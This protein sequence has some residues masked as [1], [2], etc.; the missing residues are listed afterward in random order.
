MKKIILSLIFIPVLSI[1][2]GNID[3]L[4]VGTDQNCDYN[5][6]QQALDAADGDYVVVTTQK[7]FRENLEIDSKL[8]VLIGGFSDCEAAE[9]LTLSN[10]KTTVS[11][12][13]DD[14]GIG[15]GTVLT[16]TG[17]K[18][19]EII[20]FK[21][22]EGRHVNQAGG[23]EI[24]KSADD[25]FIK[26]SLIME[27]WANSGGGIAVRQSPGVEVQLG[28]G[29][30]I[31]N[32]TGNLAGGGLYCDD[33]A[34]I[35][36]PTHVVN[37]GI[38]NNSTNLS[39]GGVYLTNG[40]QMVFQAGR[41]EHGFLDF[42]GIAGNQAKINGGG[43]MIGGGAKMYLTPPAGHTV[44]VSDN[45]ADS[46]NNGS[47]NGGG[48]FV[49]GVDS[50][51][52]ATNSYLAL[53]SAHKGGGAYVEAAGYFNWLSTAQ[54]CV[55]N[56]RCAYIK[57]NHANQQGGGIFV[58]GIDSEVELLRAAMEFNR[59]DFGTTIYVDDEAKFRMDYSIVSHNGNNGANGFFDE[60]V[61][62]AHNNAW[63]NIKQSTIADNFA[64]TAVFVTDITPFSI[65]IYNSI[66]HDPSSGLVAD[67]S[68]QQA[69]DFFAFCIMFHEDSGLYGNDVIVQNPQFINRQSRDFRIDGLQS[70]AVDECFELSSYD[71]DYLGAN[72]GWD[73]PNVMAS[74]GGY[75]M[76]A[77]E[78][79]DGDVIFKSSLED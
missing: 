34:S 61:I 35:Y 44:N 39:G 58:T 55:D 52:Q 45:I 38:S 15:D 3:V 6:I 60:G 24:R 7:T 43:I 76:G 23:V 46:D 31:I 53:N 51:F 37:A 65:N 2:A 73:D 1:Q 5:N 74:G 41:L 77:F 48:V 17:T 18:N 79:F 67:I 70:L 19:V 14:D 49:T 36:T 22:T 54:D 72:T 13:L 56:K 71:K 21:F 29:L 42:R 75:D 16:L 28:E 50:V 4:S 33:S 69:N 8:V 62:H 12:D 47:G 20:G 40:C 78:S 30:F 32:N 11:G 66:I 68:Q 57:E 64:E 26:N 27:N 10:Q 63:L 25:V 9:N 59:A